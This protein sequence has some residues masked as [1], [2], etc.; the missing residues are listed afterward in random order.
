M[1]EM[2]FT[3]WGGHLHWHYQLEALGAD[4]HGRWFAGRTGTVMR[5]GDE[6]PVGQPHDFVSL[7]PESGCWIATFNEPSA[8]T[9]I[10]VYIDVTT[11]PHLT[12]D[13]IHA[14]D[15]DLDVIRLRDG[16]VRVLDEDEF[17]EHRIRY[18]Y[19]EEVATQARA[20]TDQL[21]A[22]LTAAVQPF[23]QAAAR[24]LATLT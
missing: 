15:L 13:V 7:V 10:S 17:A 12:G 24:Y 1:T 19:P 4:A 9:D 22:L 21:V 8:D 16:S 14:V 5:R 18:G 2:R 11:R 6:P 3:K 20:T 23:E